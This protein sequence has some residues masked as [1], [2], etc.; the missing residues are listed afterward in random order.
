MACGR[1]EQINPQQKATDVGHA[2]GKR[3]NQNSSSEKTGESK[4]V[5]K[6]AMAP[7]IAVMNTEAESKNIE[8][9][10][11]RT[12]S[13]SEPH[14]IRDAGAIKAGADGDGSSRVRDN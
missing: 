6:S 9:R 4:R 10:N 13:S 5:R 1:E 11:H 12:Q 8:I 14:S 3:Q 7:E 2:L